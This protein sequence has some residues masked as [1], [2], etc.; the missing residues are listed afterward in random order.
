MALTTRTI[1]A[2]RG[3]NSEIKSYCSELVYNC[4]SLL[5]IT[6]SDANYVLF[7]EETNLG[8]DVEDD[9]NF[10]VLLLKDRLTGRID[11]LIQKT[12]EFLDTQEEINNRKF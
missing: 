9:L 8:K 4:Q 12:T 10:L 3:N 1:Q 5:D 6:R 2:G 11:E 7:T